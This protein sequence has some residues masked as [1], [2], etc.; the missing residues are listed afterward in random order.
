MLE[1]CPFRP[2]M[3]KVDYRGPQTILARHLA[4]IPKGGSIVECDESCDAAGVKLQLRPQLLLGV[5]SINE[6]QFGRLDGNRQHVRG[7]KC[8][9]YAGVFCQRGQTVD[10]LGRFCHVIR[11]KT[12]R[13]CVNQGNPGRMPSRMI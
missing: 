2:V 12:A 7:V 13:F 4:V 5:Q 10:N 11:D 6:Q 1:D 9:L 8:K 3:E